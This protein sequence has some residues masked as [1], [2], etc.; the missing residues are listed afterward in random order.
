MKIKT[1]WFMIEIKFHRICWFKYSQE[2]IDKIN[3][4]LKGELRKYPVKRNCVYFQNYD[5][6]KGCPFH[7][8]KTKITTNLNINKINIK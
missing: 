3:V 1:R 2:E 6:S 8:E 7:G 4:N 5:G